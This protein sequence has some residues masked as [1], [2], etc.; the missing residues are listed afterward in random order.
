MKKPDHNI[1][2]MISGAAGS[3]KS[4]L[5]NKI[6]S[7]LNV[8]CSG[9]RVV[10]ETGSTWRGRPATVHDKKLREVTIKMGD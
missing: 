8:V 7:Y 2:I 10:D 9:Y 1:S 6:A 5:A 4:V 3:G